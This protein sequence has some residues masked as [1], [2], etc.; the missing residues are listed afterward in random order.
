[1][2]INICTFTHRRESH[3]FSTLL[4][5]LHAPRFVSHK[6]S[7][8][9]FSLKFS[10]TLSLPCRRVSSRELEVD[11]V[12]AW[13]WFPLRH[14]DRLQQ[15]G[16][17]QTRPAEKILLDFGRG[18]N[19][20]K[21]HFREP[22]CNNSCRLFIKPFF[23]YAHNSHEEQLKDVRGVSPPLCRLWRSA[24]G[25]THQQTQMAVSFKFVWAF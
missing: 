17:D 25:Q 16:S 2:W 13:S 1:M 5:I 23:G 15:Q 6:S 8:F 3:L 10:Q 12:T 18:E 19:C 7:L 14:R 9:F 11:P 4:K 22:W 21:R 20:C 24:A